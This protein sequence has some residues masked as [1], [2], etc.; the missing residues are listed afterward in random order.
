MR[1]WHHSGR[2]D[3]EETWFL[4]EGNLAVCL[5][6][7]SIGSRRHHV[8][9]CHLDLAVSR[10]ISGPSHLCQSYSQRDGEHF[11]LVL[12]ERNLAVCLTSNVTVVISDL[13]A[14][15]VRDLERLQNEGG[16]YCCHLIWSISDVV[17]F[18]C[19][20]IAV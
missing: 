12:P 14:L 3:V 16:T 2:P 20:I 18:S 17:S 10:V 13:E 4:P 7:T 6:G 8:A 5:A 19:G 15:Q 9:E 11:R 1:S